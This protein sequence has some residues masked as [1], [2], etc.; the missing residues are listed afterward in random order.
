MRNRWFVLAAIALAM[1]T[2][3]CCFGGTTTTGGPVPPVPPIG[4]GTT[5]TAPPTVGTSMVTIGPGFMPDPQTSTGIAGGPVAA[6]GM[7]AD[8]RG[9][10]AAQ[11]NVIL[12]ATGQFTNLRVVVSSSADT[13]L[14]VQ[15]ADGSF[16]CNDDSEGLNPVVSGMFGPGQHRIW[17]GT[18]SAAQAGTQYTLGLTEL[19]HVTSASLGGGGAAVPGLAGIGAAMGALVPQECGMAVPAYGPVT[20][21]STVVLGMHTP[22]TGSDGQGAMVTADTNWATEMQPWVGQRTT[23][24]SLGGLD[25]A[26]C[27]GIRVA[28]DEGQ[29]FW[30]L[31]NVTF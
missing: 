12:N 15:R 9:F 19:M 7:S 27:P 24:T 4:T 20:V 6:T 1:G 18:Y 5:G 30:R 28:A 14:V 2:T 10:V 31:R 22:W 26:G 8:C 25:Q 11:P 29:Y 13:T 3:G 21:G 16:V 23:V 17:I